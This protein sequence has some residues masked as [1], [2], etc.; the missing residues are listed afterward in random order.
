[1]SQQ[2]SS[3]KPV[4]P[5]AS[6]REI[7]VLRQGGLRDFALAIG[8]LESLRKSH[9][10]ARITLACQPNLEDL[11]ELCPFVDAV[12]TDLCHDDKKRRAAKLA[13][14]R[15]TRFD[16]IYDFDGTEQSERILRALRPRFG[17]PPPASGPTAS[18]TFSGAAEPGTV[19]E[20]ERLSGQLILAG[21]ELIGLPRPQ[22]AWV[23]HKLSH[24]PRLQPDYFGI[25]GDFALLSV[26]P[27]GEDDPCHW[28]EPV[29]AELCKRLV[30]AG[31]TPVM[32]GP[33][34]A[35][36][37]AQRVEMA[38]RGAKNVVGRADAPQIIS[39][40]EAA[41]VVIG[42][43]GAAL[44]IA[45]IF[46]TPCLQLIPTTAARAGI[47]T[48]HFSQHITLHGPNISAISADTL[49]QTLT[50]WKGSGVGKSLD[51]SVPNRH[52]T[53]Q[54]P[55]LSEEICHSSQTPRGRTAEENRP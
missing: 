1:M 33:S 31:I 36:H 41:S 9:R 6:A 16:L 47:N 55:T 18:A 29:V 15:R 30:Q 23:R 3:S 4:N 42:P 11:A 28:P 32:T 35:G 24:P 27:P 37:L 45:G 44:Q 12:I 40:A 49:W 19:S 2:V 17:A 54:D 51:A 25:A 14:M 20:I 8:A 13:E 34:E 48:P 10:Y 50:C 53:D 7:L 38:E 26:T 52:I 43:D 5:G 22:L 46:G 39:L 21:V